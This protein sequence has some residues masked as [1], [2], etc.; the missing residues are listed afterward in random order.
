MT[1]LLPSLLLL[2]ISISMS[3]VF[4]GCF[5]G[6]E[7]FRDQYYDLWEKLGKEKRDLLRGQ[8]QKAHEDQA[9]AAEE[10]EDV[11]TKIKELYGFDGGNLEKMYNKIKGDYDRCEARVKAVDQRITKITEIAE[12]L[13][14]E[15]ETELKQLTNPEFKTKSREALAKTRDR[16]E[17]LRAAM[18]KADNSMKPA[19][20][21]LSNYVVFLK[22]NLNAQAIGSLQTEVDSIERE[23]TAIKD[24]INAS[25]KEAEEFLKDFK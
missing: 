12:D 7:L 19:L 15:W 21:N 18:L 2:V 24:D 13:F 14:A 3:L 9:E 4:T 8:I 22:H 1:R 6:C 25:I 11:L 20:K 5:G 10:F 23:I 16:F 17:Q